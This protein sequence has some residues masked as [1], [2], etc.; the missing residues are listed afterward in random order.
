VASPVFE[1]CAFRNREET[2]AFRGSERGD[3]CG[4]G[5]EVI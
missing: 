3:C 4:P 1:R 2:F 5:G